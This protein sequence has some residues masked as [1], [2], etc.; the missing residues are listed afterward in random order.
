[1]WTI[2]WWVIKDENSE[3]QGEEFFTELLGATKE[4]HK[5]YVEQ[6]FPDTYVKCLGRVTR[7]DADDMGLD[8]Y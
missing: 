3:Y 1:M 2:Y 8:T 6:L 7:E 4:E 5:A